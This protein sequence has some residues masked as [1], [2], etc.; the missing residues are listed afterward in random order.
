MN[1]YSIDPC[2]DARWLDL[3]R[4]HRDGSVFHHPGWLDALRANYRYEP[5][6]LTTSAPG[7][8]LANG[9][10]FCRV[11]S[12]LTGKRLVSTPFSDH[13]QPLVDNREEALALIDHARELGVRER[14]KYVELRSA[15]PLEW[16]A[17]AGLG[18]SLEAQLHQIDLAP[19]ADALFKA[20]H[21]SS[22]V[23][24]IKRADREGLRY[25]SGTT[26]KLL[27]DFYA[28]MVM[29]RRKHGLPPQ[30]RAWFR[31]VLDR[32]PDIAK[33]HVAY[34]DKTATAAIFTCAFGGRYVYKYGCSDPEY[35]N[36]GGTPM[37]FWRAIQEAKAGGYAWFDLGR[38]D[39]GHD[40][41][42][43]FKERWG[44]QALP[45]MY[46]RSPA[47]TPRGADGHV[48]LIKLAEPIIDRLPDAL[49]IAAGRILY[50]H[51]G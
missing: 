1:V 14:C 50:R 8:P 47:P 4:R 34:K 48:G 28:L 44:A 36:A 51:M 12:V 33:I 19:S 26:D 46:Y 16:A 3:I 22:I 21:D 9:I 30:P 43:T 49:L 41:L 13:A 40:G 20:F 23:R 15:G 25:E 6:A 32:L 17:D 27:D 24:K 38:T 5:F 18:V 29:T 31:S 42:A 10:V 37:L 7:E 11:R 2:A 45:L 39:L 35:T